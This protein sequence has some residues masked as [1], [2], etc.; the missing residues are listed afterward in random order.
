[1]TISDINIDIQTTSNSKLNSIDFE[2]LQ[3][4]KDF[5]DHMFSA[6][7]NGKEWESLK[8][9][10]FEN[11]SMSPASAVIHYGQAIFEGMKVFKTA[12]GKI[13]TFR[14][15]DN[16]KRLN[17]SAERMCMAQLP[18]EIFMAGLKQL[19][20]IDK[21]WIPVGESSSLYVRP[22][23]FATDA[24]LGVKP[25]THYKFMIITSPVGTYYKGA[26]DVKIETDYSRAH[27]GGT[28][29][30]KA[31]GNY[32]AALY[33]AKLAQ[34]QGYHQ[35]IWTD[36]REHKYFEESGTMNVMFLI[37]N[38]LVT[39]PLTSSILPGITRDSILTIARD[40]GMQVEERKIS[41]DEVID[42][43]K[44]NQLQE[45][46]GVGTAATVAQIRSIGY[47]NEKFMLPEIEQREFS[48]KVEKYLMALK[49]G[50]E[51]DKFGWITEL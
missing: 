51:V 8:I 33:P 22:F 44:N 28:G 20:N 1:M 40:W 37:N 13:L 24:F 12:E 36:A 49:R 10:P 18:E 30:A 45:A 43:I 50:L 7:Y 35:L 15:L 16:L 32:A 23:M 5:A 42:A 46:F 29:S 31:A 9:T 11:M 6:D 21:G 19:V 38:V 14:A 27:P 41:I 48:P 4:G 3:F 39:P 26:V 25:S 17:K 47:N 34:D 2:H